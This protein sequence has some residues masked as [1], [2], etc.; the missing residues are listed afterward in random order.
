M[1]EGDAA[2][3]N[4]KRLRRIAALLLAFAGLAERAGTRSLAIRLLV[5]LVLRLGE[6]IAWRYAARLTDGLPARPVHPA[7]L[8]GRDGPGEAA[9][10]ARSFRILAAVLFALAPVP[11][12]GWRGGSCAGSCGGV[13]AG[14]ARAAARLSLAVERRDTS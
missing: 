9:R 3:M 14:P 5:L 10:L 8:P 6:D 7:S 13:P 12:A 1:D 4:G 11:S 2:E